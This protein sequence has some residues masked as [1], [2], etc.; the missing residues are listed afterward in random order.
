MSDQLTVKCELIDNINTYYLLGMDKFFNNY[1]LKELDTNEY[2]FNKSEYKEYDNFKL[3][4]VKDNRIYKINDEV[5]LRTTND[6][7]NNTL[8]LF[9][10]KSY[11]GISI[12]INHKDIYDKYLLYEVIN[13]NKELILETK[14]I[15]VLSNV[16]KENHI[17]YVE[18]Y[19][20]YDD[21]YLLS[22]TT[23]PE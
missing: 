1:K 21:Y 7:I 14:D 23:S 4:Y 16:L 19:T 12:Q 2:S 17:Y 22:N 5:E 13:G 20:K 6:F 3:A 11:R 8:K 15:L 9:F 10:I 18:A